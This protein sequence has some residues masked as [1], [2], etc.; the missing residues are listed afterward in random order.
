MQVDVPLF[1][2]KIKPLF[3]QALYCSV[4]TVRADGMP[5][6]SPIGSVV[7]TDHQRG[8]FFQKFT[9]NI[10]KNAVQCE[11]ATIMAVNAGRW[12]WLKSLFKGGFKSPPAMRLQV[13]LG[14]LRSGDDTE[15]EKFQRRVSLFKRTRG[16]D[17]MWKD[18]SQ[19]REFEIIGYEPVYIGAMTA[20]QFK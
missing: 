4:A 17:L 5:H 16:Y 9:K 15:I 20:K 6:V 3:T 19:V 11:Y 13:K 18:M 2:N 10:P 14:A 1:K 12:F 7:L 8:W